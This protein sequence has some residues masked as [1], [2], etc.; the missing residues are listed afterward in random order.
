[1][2]DPRPP[3]PDVPFDSVREAIRLPPAAVDLASPILARDTA[4]LT[5]RLRALRRRGGPYERIVPSR[6]FSRLVAALA[7]GDPSNLVH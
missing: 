1:M 4:E 3:S 7:T 5:R 6:R 2:S